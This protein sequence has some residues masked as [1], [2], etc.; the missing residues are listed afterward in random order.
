MKK[1][2]SRNY[3][4]IKKILKKCKINLNQKNNERI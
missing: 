4:N 1:N 3:K 2:E